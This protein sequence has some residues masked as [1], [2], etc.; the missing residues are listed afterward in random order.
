MRWL[1]SLIGLGILLGVGLCI[2]GARAN[3]DGGALPSS[4]M[5]AGFHQLYE[6]RFAEARTEFH[7]WEKGQPNDAMGPMAEAAS[8]LFE[9]FNAQ[10]VLSSEY[11]LDDEHFLGGKPLKPNQERRAAFEAAVGCTEKLARA[12][13]H[14][15]PDDANALLALSAT[16]GMRADYAS[17]IEKK[18]IESLGL[19]K[20]ADTTARRV[21]AIDP[22]LADAN[23]SIGTA[24]YIIGCLPPYKRF[25]LWFG[26]IHGDR[27]A[28]MERL[29]MT[30]ENGHYLRPY[31]QLMLAL[32]ALREKQN[33]L[34]RTELQQLVAEFPDNPA[35][36]RELEKLN[37][38]GVSAEP[39]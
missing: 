23:V 32:A 13:L 29:R 12:R 17:I 3:A 35:F 7:A 25:I 36:S 31:G 24:Q 11:F 15:H 6:M 39:R 2:A 8:Y 19:L 21:L 33:D 20:D 14:D 26:G 16:E 1:A 5:D 38:Q 18:Q 30:A 37:Q 9:E 28:G 27:A 4:Q 22:S 10:G 34:A